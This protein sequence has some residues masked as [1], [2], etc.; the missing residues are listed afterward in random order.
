MAIEGPAAE[1]VDGAVVRPDSQLSFFFLSISLIAV[2]V[3]FLKANISNLVGALIRERILEEIVALLSFIWELIWELL[4]Q[5]L[6]CA[7]LGEAYGWRYG[8]G[9]AGIG[10]IFGLV[11]FISGSKNVATVGL[12]PDPIL[13]ETIYFGIKAERL[14][15][16]FSLLFVLI[17]WGLFSVLEDLGILL[18]LIGL[19]VLV[20]LLMYLFKKCNRKERNQ[21]I[22]VLVLMAFSVFFWALFEQAASSI[23]LFTDRNVNIGNTFSAGMFQAFNPLFIVVF[24][25]M[26]AYLWI[27]LWETKPRTRSR[28]KVCNSDF[29]CGNWFYGTSFRRTVCRR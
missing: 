6:F 10:M 12:P 3:G 28:Y 27:F 14:I 15:Y 11:T 9:V 5:T 2:G 13:L 19:P 25:P 16:F 23:T 8:F 22:V 1:I 26:F 21:T 17:I 24:A 4:L 7:Y 29:V 20:W 18:S